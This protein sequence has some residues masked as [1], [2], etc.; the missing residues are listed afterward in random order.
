MNFF[1]PLFCVWSTYLFYLINAA[2][3]NEK[4]KRIW[5]IYLWYKKNTWWLQWWG[6][7][8][9]FSL[10][11]KKN[12]IKKTFRGHTEAY[13]YCMAYKNMHFLCSSVLNPFCIRSILLWNIHTRRNWPQIFDYSNPPQLRYPQLRYFRSYRIS[14]YSC[15]GNY[16]F[17]NSSSEETIQVFISLM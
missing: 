13:V 1:L 6:Q 8:W 9:F 10:L 16:S 7:L 4:K 14:S 17:L 5:W 11:M 15:R 12:S 3:W 2:K